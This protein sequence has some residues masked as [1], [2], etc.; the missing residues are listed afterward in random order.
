MGNGPSTGFHRTAI[1]THR[2]RR[3][4]S[5]ADLAALL[6]GIAV[7]VCG[8]GIGTEVEHVSDLFDGAQAIFA[9]SLVIL[10]VAGNW[11]N[12][13]RKRADD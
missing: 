4:V 3:D 13:Y 5:W 6:I 1:K 11:L 9:T 12:K 7:A 8:H 2:H 10:A